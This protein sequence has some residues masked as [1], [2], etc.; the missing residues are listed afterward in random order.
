MSYLYPAHLFEAAQMLRIDFGAWFR[1]LRA[2]RCCHEGHE[3]RDG[4][5]NFD[6]INRIKRTEDRLALVGTTAAP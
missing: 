6:R 4:A 2:F 1:I 3:R 5:R